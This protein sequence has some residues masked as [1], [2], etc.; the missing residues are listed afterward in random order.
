LHGTRAG[1]DEGGC[2]SGDS[3]RTFLRGQFHYATCAKAYLNYK[4]R[5]EQCYATALR[6]S[7]LLCNRYEAVS[8]N[9]VVDDEAVSISPGNRI[10]DSVGLRSF[11][12][13]GSKVIP[14]RGYVLKRRLAISDAHG[15][16]ICARAIQAFRDQIQHLLRYYLMHHLQ[17]RYFERPRASD[18]QAVGV[19]RAPVFG[20]FVDWG[21]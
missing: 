7:V 5:A 2:S 10:S 9:G 19:E 8:S 4:D 15:V 11:R 14:V 18:P 3:G 6:Q 21:R 16:G 12:V 1:R 17:S 20:Y 13:V